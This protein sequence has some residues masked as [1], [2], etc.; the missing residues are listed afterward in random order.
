MY[1]GIEG[2][3]KMADDTLLLAKEAILKILFSYYPSYMPLEDIIKLSEDIREKSN[4]EQILFFNAM[5]ELEQE[6]YVKR[7]SENYIA[8]TDK[9]FEYIYKKPHLIN[10]RILNL[11]GETSQRQEA[12]QIEIKDK[13]YRLKELSEKIEIIEQ[14]IDKK[15]KALEDKIDGFNLK[16]I[17]ISAVILA[18]FTFLNININSLSKINEL[19]FIKSVVYIGS[20]NICFAIGIALIIIGLKIC[21]NKK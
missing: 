14:S 1:D 19:P 8:I 15:S 5:Q 9:G 2:D 12:L 21:F 10:P 3:V 16:I 11:I 13:E 4:E 6:N 17:E 20:I 7:S 18:L